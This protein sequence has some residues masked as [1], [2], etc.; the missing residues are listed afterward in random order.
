MFIYSL[1]VSIELIH[2]KINNTSWKMAIFSK[3]KQKSDFL[4]HFLVSLM[5]SLVKDSWIPISASA[6]N[7]LPYAFLLEEKT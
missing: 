3:T 5:S 6:L 1:K 4:L 2:V 7:L